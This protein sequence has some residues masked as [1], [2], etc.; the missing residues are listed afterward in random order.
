VDLDTVRGLFITFGNLKQHAVL[1]PTPTSHPLN[2]W[3]SYPGKKR[4]GREA[5]HSPPSSDEVTDAQNFTSNPPIRLHSVCL[6][7]QWM[8][9]H[10]VVL[11]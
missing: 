9:L 7:N 5:D 10:G 3:G 11:S 6:I 8:H 4:P 1:G 2:T